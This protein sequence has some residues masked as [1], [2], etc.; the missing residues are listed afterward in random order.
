MYVTTDYPEELEVAK[1]LIQSAARA[2]ILRGRIP[3]ASEKL[4]TIV[5]Q[6]VQ[7][8][9]RAP[10]LGLADVPMGVIA[11]VLRR[12]SEIWGRY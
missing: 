6:P 5:R 8:Y 7:S 12:H 11:S 9:T 4:E 1:R 10:F 3:G 2:R